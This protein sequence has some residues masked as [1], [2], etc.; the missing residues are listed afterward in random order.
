MRSSG[1]REII[2]QLP[3]KCCRWTLVNN[4]I[5]ERGRFD[6]CTGITTLGQ[7]VRSRGS[8]ILCRSN[9]VDSRMDSRKPSQTYTR[10]LDPAHRGTT[11]QPSETR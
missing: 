10:S 5:D 4:S 11:P 1:N 3:R 2:G 8:L 9:R 6:A 7:S